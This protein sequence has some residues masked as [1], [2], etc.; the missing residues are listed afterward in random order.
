LRALNIK[1]NVIYD[2]PYIVHEVIM[3]P[4]SN[5][6]LDR[7]NIDDSFALQAELCQ[8]LT[9]PFRLKLLHLLKTGEKNVSDLED[10]TKLN[11]PFISQHLRVLRDKDVVKTRREKNVVYY[12][13]SD[14]KIVEICDIV[15]EIIKKKQ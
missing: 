12:S 6:K 1:G 9:H 11:Q 13:L 4:L 14:P 8:S 15:A 3:A 2:K 10:L 5:R 7:K